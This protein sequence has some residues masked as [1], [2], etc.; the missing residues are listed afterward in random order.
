M[1]TIDGPGMHGDEPGY[2]S[3]Q[4]GQRGGPRSP[5]DVASQETDFNS[6]AGYTLSGNHDP[7]HQEQQYHA[8][9]QLAS[10]T[11]QKDIETKSAS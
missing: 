11:K 8:S 1:Q 6:M 3:H 2:G 10:G 4:Q 9:R 5:Q 7:T